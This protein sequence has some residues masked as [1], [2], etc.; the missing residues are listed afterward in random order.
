MRIIQR[1]NAETMADWKKSILIYM[2]VWTICVL[3]FWFGMDGGEWIMAYTILSF[4]VYLPVT[5]LIIA[6]S[7]SH[8]TA[9]LILPHPDHI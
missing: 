5:T 3:W 6:A 4:G 9:R 2:T 8:H 7:Y 1:K